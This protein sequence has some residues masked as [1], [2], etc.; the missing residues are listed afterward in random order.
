MLR[1]NDRISLSKPPQKQTWSKAELLS[2]PHNCNC[3]GRRCSAGGLG[4]L[5][6]FCKLMLVTNEGKIRSCPPSLRSCWYWGGGPG[7]LVEHN[8]LNIYLLVILLLLNWALG[9]VKLSFFFHMIT[10]VIPWLYCA[11]ASTKGNC[12]DINCCKYKLLRI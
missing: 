6:C 11:M 1:T 2:L 7:V 9:L 10:Q 4:C 8:R 5:K 12:E 3:R